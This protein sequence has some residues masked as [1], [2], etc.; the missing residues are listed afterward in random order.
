MEDR[1]VVSEVG[2]V[3][4]G[5]ERGYE[6][7]GG[8]RVDFDRCFPHQSLDP[9]LLLGGKKNS[10]YRHSVGVGPFTTGTAGI[11]QSFPSA[12]KAAPGLIW[13]QVAATNVVPG[14]KD[15]TATTRPVKPGEAV[16]VWP[17]LTQYVR[18]DGCGA[19][20]GVLFLKGDG[21]ELGYVFS[22]LSSAFFSF[23]G[24]GGEEKSGGR[25]RGGNPPLV[26][27]STS[28]STMFPSSSTSLS[29][30]AHTPPLSLQPNSSLQ[31]SRSKGFCPSSPRRAS[32]PARR[33][34]SRR[35][36]A[37][38]AAARGP[39][40]PAPGAAGPRRRSRT[41]SPP[42]PPP[43]PQGA[44]RRRRSLDFDVFFSACFV[45]DVFFYWLHLLFCASPPTPGCRQGNQFLSLHL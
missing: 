38:G 30:F 12:E 20:E 16:A 40:G 10:S 25:K 32:R 34:K 44:P 31:G 41:K 9:N 15:A 43:P 6:G 5:V 36:S 11:F 8:S 27:T 23:Y 39:T 22:I 17:S 37:E 42:R 24:K 33:A 4:G 13:T 1:A 3:G 14:S 18:N 45:P 29:P 28:T 19:A 35:R 7:L 2:D 26:P 21:D